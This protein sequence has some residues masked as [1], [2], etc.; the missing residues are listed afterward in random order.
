MSENQNTLFFTQDVEES[1]YVVNYLSE[2]MHLLSRQ[3]QAHL[4]SGLLSSGSSDEFV[5][6][7]R[8]A[9]HYEKVKRKWYTEQRRRL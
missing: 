4:V 6:T 5:A 7:G 9:R 8:A 1:Y 2:H 3:T